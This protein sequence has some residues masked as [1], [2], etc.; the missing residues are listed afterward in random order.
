MINMT[1]IL[2][3]LLR[4]CQK[5]PLGHGVE[6]LTY[7]RNRGLA[8][9]RQDED[10]YLVLEHGYNEE[11]FE[12]VPASKLKKLCKTLLKR[13]F[14]RSTKA[15]LYQLGEFHENAWRDTQRKVL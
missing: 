15:R 1:V 3:T 6:V 11:R 10:T 4:R 7:K 2:D 5:L 13:E 12:D 14:P 9:V 8:L